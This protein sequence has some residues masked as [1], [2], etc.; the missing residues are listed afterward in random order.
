[1]PPQ[2]QQIPEEQ[3]Q[4][5][6]GLKRNSTSLWKENFRVRSEMGYENYKRLNKEEKKRIND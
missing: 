4:E 3:S 2:D 5:S 6:L 1:M